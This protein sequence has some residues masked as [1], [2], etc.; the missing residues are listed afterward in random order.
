MTEK[1]RPY[2]D[3]GAFR[4]NLLTEQIM[5]EMV[6]FGRWSCYVDE[7]RPPSLGAI[8]DLEAVNDSATIPNSTKFFGA[9]T[10]VIEERRTAGG[11]PKRVLRNEA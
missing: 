2:S 7:G 11:L 6:G 8:P 9:R 10:S 3:S 1:R 4:L 5:L